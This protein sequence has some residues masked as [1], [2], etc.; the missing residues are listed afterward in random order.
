LAG[1]R[2]VWLPSTQIECA[3]PYYRIGETLLSHGHYLDGEVR[4]SVSNRLL[5]DGI[6]RLAGGRAATPSIEDY[7]APLVPLTELL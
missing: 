4:G 2:L 6:R 1:K 7:E 5:Q 3:Y